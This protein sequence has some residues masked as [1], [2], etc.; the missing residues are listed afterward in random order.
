MIATNIDGTTGSGDANQVFN[1]LAVVAN[2]DMYAEK[3]RTLMEATAEHKK[4]LALVAPANEILAIRQQIDQDKAN[5]KA[6]LEK[7][8]EDAAK[9][10]ADAKV[11]AKGIVDDAKEQG[12]KTAATAKKVEKQ[13]ADKMAAAVE[14][15]RKVTE[16]LAEAKALQKSLDDKIKATDALRAEVEK[17]K[18][19]HEAL[20]ASLIAKHKRHLQE[21]ES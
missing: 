9:L 2:P 4:F 10:V 14:A 18:A 8:R 13:A 17:L 20:K 12:S 3:V 21:L 16:A 6:E 19:E 15:E 7:A 5:A 1:L 11:E